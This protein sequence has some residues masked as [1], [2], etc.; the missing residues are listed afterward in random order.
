MLVTIIG[1]SD[2]CFSSRSSKEGYYNYLVRGYRE[3]VF[4]LLL[5]LH[6]NKTVI[7]KTV[8]KKDALGTNRKA[9]NSDYFIYY[10]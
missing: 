6:S 8:I 7:K 10:Y 2:E 4:R 5:E 1:N 3:D 9:G